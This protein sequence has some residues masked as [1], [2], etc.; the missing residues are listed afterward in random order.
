MV[1]VKRTSLISET[2]LQNPLAARAVMG[3]RDRVLVPEPQFQEKV[4]EAAGMQPDR[5]ER[6]DRIS[7]SRAK[8]NIKHC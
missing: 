3:F 5:L 4:L 6:H 1:L 2:P 8:K 7:S